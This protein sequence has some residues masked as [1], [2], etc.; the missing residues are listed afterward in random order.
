MSP[1]AG[2]GVTLP[3]LL[4]ALAVV[5]LLLGLAV[6]R[7]QSALDRVAVREAA[8]AIAAAHRGARELALAEGRITELEVA[9]DSLRIGL[10]LGAA[11]LPRWAAPGPAAEGI[12]LTGPAHPLVFAPTGLPLGLANATF[13][14]SRGGARRQVVISRYGRVRIIP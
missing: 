2:S 3:E 5:G 7:L 12:A 6:P 8:H 9:A 13:V 10:R 4:A 14:V 11:L 1:R